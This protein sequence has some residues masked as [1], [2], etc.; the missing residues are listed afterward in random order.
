MLLGP[1]TLEDLEHGADTEDYV[2]A[3]RRFHALKQDESEFRIQGDQHPDGHPF[4]RSAAFRR[5]LRRQG[6][7]FLGPGTNQR[8]LNLLRQVN[9][10]ADELGSI[11]RL[12]LACHHIR[13]L[14]QRLRGGLGDID[15]LRC[16][17]RRGSEF[18]GRRG[19]RRHR[20][21]ESEEEQK[22]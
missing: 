12:Q 16:R 11:R 1:V 13:L 21:G 3:G 4:Q 17:S 22:D 9:R 18:G 19:L 8:R 6:K 14:Q 20:Y 5:Y 15:A 2:P 7:Q 10:T